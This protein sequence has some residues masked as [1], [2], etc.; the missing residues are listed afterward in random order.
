MRPL[1]L[2]CLVAGLAALD[3]AEA[4][5]LLSR[6]GFAPTLDEI[7][8]LLPMT[9]EEAV[10]HLLDGVDDDIHARPPVWTR[11]SLKAFYKRLELEPAMM[12]RRGMEM[13]GQEDRREEHGRALKH[14]WYDQMLATD[15]PLT[16]RLVLMWHNHFT[17]ELEKVQAARWMWDQQMLFREHAI[18]NSGRLCL[19]IPLDP[20]MFHYLD[21]ASNDAVEPNENF[22]REVMELFTLGEGNYSE[23]DIKEAARAFTGYKFNDRTG[24]PELKRGFHDKGRKA[25]LGHE[26]KF[27][28]EAIITILLVR[29]E[30]V[31]LHLAE[32]FWREFIDERPEAREIRE[33]AKV[34]YTER[35]ELRPL[36]RAVLLH[37]RFWAEETR[38]RLVKSPAEYLV[39][40]TRQL[41]LA[42]VT[43]ADL[44]PLAV[45]LGMDLFDPP[46]VK[47]WGGHVNWINTESL[48]AGASVRASLLEDRELGAVDGHWLPEAAELG[49]YARDLIVTTMVPFTTREP[50]ADLTPRDL[51]RHLLA[52]PAYLL[53]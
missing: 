37:E 3:H 50:P 36:L 35:Y 40:A 34:L 24:R 51:A 41:G 11:L 25:V 29:E 9:R 48:A 21:S 43:G 18:G 13:M 38:G 14:W 33:L 23:Q 2:C 5:H 8:A 49:E 15:S 42:D 45:R 30:Q 7:E 53:K 1:L 44:H 16:E 52:D 47:G 27:D 10:D 12:K 6:T 46:G 26:G 39:G 20:A 17:S 4:R 19:S 32:K 31:A 22:A 28:A